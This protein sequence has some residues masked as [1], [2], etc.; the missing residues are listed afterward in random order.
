MR[1]WECAVL[2]LKPSPLLK[3]LLSPRLLT[4]TPV[5]EGAHTYSL[6]VH[7]YSQRSVAPSPMQVPLGTGRNMPPCH[8]L[9]ACSSR[10]RHH[11]LTKRILNGLTD[12]EA[13]C[14]LAGDLLEGLLPRALEG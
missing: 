14:G 10:N 1:K 13:H 2:F 12:R 4:D 3:E 11:S 8:P 6:R 9:A 5:A 7:T